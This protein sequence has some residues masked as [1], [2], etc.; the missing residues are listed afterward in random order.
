M[1]AVPGGEQESVTLLLR[2]AVL[3]KRLSGGGHYKK[4]PEKRSLGQ[5]LG[6]RAGFERLAPR[7]AGGHRDDA[8][9]HASAAKRLEP[10]AAEIL[11]SSL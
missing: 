3:V 4:S 5:P 7:V 11:A 6:T 2:S 1:L 9:R 8:L 10:S